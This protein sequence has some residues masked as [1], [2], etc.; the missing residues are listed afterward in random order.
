MTKL[1]TKYPHTSLSSLIL[2]DVY[3]PYDNRDKLINSLIKGT[4]EEITLSSSG[5]QEH[6]FSY[7]DDI[8]KCLDQ[9][10][11]LKRNG[12]HKIYFM[13]GERL[14]LKMALNKINEIIHNK[15]I[16]IN[17]G[18]SKTPPELSPY[19]PASNVLEQNIGDS[20]ERN[21]LNLKGLLDE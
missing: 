20:F 11:K 13:P 2:Y 7:I 17:W 12:E 21:I 6:I 4:N 8:I 16:K 1:S 9:I 18:N 5:D 10:V 15:K 3:G 14:T 19:I